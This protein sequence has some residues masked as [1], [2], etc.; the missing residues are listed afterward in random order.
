[1]PCFILIDCLASASD[2]TIEQF[3]ELIKMSSITVLYRVS[4]NRSTPA[5]VLETLARSE[6][7]SIATPWN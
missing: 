2:T 7:D 3:E 6:Y 1:M 5:R 4:R